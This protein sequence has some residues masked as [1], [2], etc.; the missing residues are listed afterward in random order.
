MSA[1]HY[2][3]IAR[4]SDMIVFECLVNKDYKQP[5]LRTFA[6]D[7]LVQKERENKNKLT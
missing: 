3:F 2:C 5:Q 6:V 1:V 7:L 4:D